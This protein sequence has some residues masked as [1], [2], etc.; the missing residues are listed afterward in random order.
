VGVPA[1]RDGSKAIANGIWAV[2]SVIAAGFQVYL[3]CKF[4]TRYVSNIFDWAAVGVYVGASDISAALAVQTW[5]PESVTTRVCMM[6][7]PVNLGKWSV[8]ENTLVPEKIFLDPLLTVSSLVVNCGALTSG[9]ID[10]TEMGTRLSVLNRDMDLSPAK[11]WRLAGF[12]TS[13]WVG[14]GARM[15]WAD[16]AGRITQGDAKSGQD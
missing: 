16:E 6:F 9:T 10:E 8:A 5:F 3:M 13:W 12:A 4:F 14:L 7:D 11:F 1:K 15:A 2:A